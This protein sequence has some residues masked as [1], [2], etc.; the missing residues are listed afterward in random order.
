[1]TGPGPVDCDEGSDPFDLAY[2]QQ[3][4]VVRHLRDRMKGLAAVRERAELQL[5]ELRTQ[6]AALE[7]YPEVATDSRD[8]RLARGL[9]V[10]RSDIDGQIAELTFQI[11]LVTAQERSLATTSQRLQGHVER[12]RTEKELLKVSYRAADALIAAIEAMSV[13]SATTMEATET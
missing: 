9:P 3:L 13:A 12:F 11:D 1:M 8:E 7:E 4:E 2:E 10:R 5:Q 6:A